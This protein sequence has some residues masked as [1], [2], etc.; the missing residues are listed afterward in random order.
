[1][2]D[3]ITCAIGTSRW[4]GSMVRSTSNQRFGSEDTAVSPICFS[5]KWIGMHGELMSTN[6]LN[7]KDWAYSFQRNCKGKA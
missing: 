7:L 3:S 6:T 1:M 4:V 5:D 2:S